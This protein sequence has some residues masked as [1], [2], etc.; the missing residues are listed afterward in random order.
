MYIDSSVSSDSSESER[1]PIN[2]SIIIIINMESLKKAAKF[3]KEADSLLITAGAGI[4]IDSGLPD[5]RSKNGLYK[6]FPFFKDSK[7]NF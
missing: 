4:G 3:V 1:G 7:I 5:F 6:A 2:S